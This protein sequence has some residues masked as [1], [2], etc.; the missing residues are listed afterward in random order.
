VTPAKGTKLSQYRLEEKIGAGGMGEVWKA[1]DTSLDR[2]VAVKILPEALSDDAHRLARFE[3]EAK[4]LASLNHP[5]IAVVHGLHRAEGIHFLAMELVG[6]ND[7]SQRLVRGPLPIEEAVAIARQVAEALEA[8]HES[9][10]VHRDLKP[11]NIQVTP[12]GKVKVL[13]F[14]LA[15]AFDQEPGSAQGAVSLSPTMTAAATQAGV[16]LGTAAYMSPEQA[17]G[18]AVDRRAD[19][20]AFGCV[21]Y[22]MLAGKRLFEGDTVS[23]IL[24]AVLR[25]DPDW[26]ALPAAT[27]PAIR[28]LLR[29]CLEKDPRRRLQA[30]GDARIALDGMLPAQEGPLPG[31]DVRPAPASRFRER[32]AWAVAAVLAVASVGVVLLSRPRPGPAAVVTRSLIAPP[33]GTQFDF[34]GDHSGSLSISPDGRHVTF[35]V[36]SPTGDT[37]LWIRPSDSFE[38]HPLPGTR[39]ATWPFWSPDSQYIA[40]F[41]EGKLKR[42]DL[43]GSPPI[44]ICDARDGRGGSWGREG[45]IVF[46]PDTTSGIY[47]VAATGGT[48]QAQTALDKARGETTHRWPAFLPDG[49][50]FLFM[51]GTHSQGIRSEAN[52]VYVAEIGKPGSRRLLLARSNVEYSSGHLLYVRDRVLLAQPFDP[53]RLELRGEPLPLAEGVAHQQDYFRAVFA[54]SENGVLVFMT[55]TTTSGSRLTWYGR[56]GKPVQRVA[57]LDSYDRIA[58]SP[59]GKR[60]AFTLVDAESGLKDV[61]VLDLLRGVRTRLTFGA[62]GAGFVGKD[63][64]IWSPDGTRIAY[65]VTAL[66]DDLFVRPAAGGDEQ[67]LL[68]TKSDKR[69]TD[70]SQDGRILVFDQQGATPNSKYG[71][72]VWPFDGK[73]EPRPFVDSEFNE[74]GGRL[75][76]DGRWML[77]SSDE[78]GRFELYVAPYPGPGGK[79]QI[80][81]AGAVT[82]WWTLGGKEIVFATPDRSMMSVTV[83]ASGATFEV[84]APKLLFTE[85]L[86]VDGTVTPDGRRF[87]LGVRPEADQDLP[88]TLVTSW[89]AGLKR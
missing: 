61:W 7:L 17:R 10:I 22:E 88:L 67:P 45:V 64:P 66:V 71:V 24:A 76:P 80:S 78:S 57:D 3:R 37:S 86:M 29:W 27:P 2:S 59:E 8:A 43:A 18:R 9:G 63:A 73:T 47:S 5:N 77:Y 53:D 83:R 65:T 49:R 55:G 56:D 51:A 16:I 41:A 62:S 1:V 33:A 11:A 20:W 50:H 42:I 46:S 21:L 60:V 39:S 19:I 34:A 38:A 30:I 58:L 84:D 25:S 72:W 69:P 70:W 75:S 68:R 23:D 54:V 31:T 82:G 13:D 14:G 74:R 85:P 35:S 87:L 12:E 26:G 44:A 52:A 48:P 81:A 79:W 4:V 15:K 6:G 32:L 28:A 40:F 36:M 89:P